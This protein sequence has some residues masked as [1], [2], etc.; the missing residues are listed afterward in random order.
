MA[1]I[2]DQEEYQ[3][4]IKTVAIRHSR[5]KLQEKKYR[6]RRSTL[7]GLGAFA[8]VFF[9]LLLII[10][11]L[12]AL[13]AVASAS[14][15]TEDNGIYRGDSDLGPVIGIDLGTTYSVVGVM[16]SNGVVEIIANDQG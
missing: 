12:A 1:E 7:F 3:Q 4:F 9:V 14:S 15:S 8:T 6:A 13:P 16:K 10:C 11:P 2:T 5:E